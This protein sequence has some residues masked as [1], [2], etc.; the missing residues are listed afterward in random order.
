[1]ISENQIYRLKCEGI[2][3][4]GK[5]VSNVDSF[6]IFID[7]F[8]TGEIADIKITK[9][10]KNFGFGIITN[11]IQKSPH[12]IDSLCGHSSLS[13]TCPFNDIT[14]E[15]ELK[16]KSEIVKH[17][18]T[19]KTSYYKDIE[20][21]SSED[22][23]GYRNKI[24]VFFNE[25]N[26]KIKY[27]YFKEK[28]NDFIEVDYC[29]QIDDEINKLLKHIIK[30]LEESNSSI[31]NIRKKVGHIKG[32][33]IRKSSYTK[34]IIIMF[35]STHNIPN[36]DFIKDNLL[37]FNKNISGIS[38][39]INKSY[40]TFIYSG[41]IIKV[42]G[43]SYIDEKI[44]DIIFRVDNLSFLQVNTS[45]ASLLYKYAIDKANLTKDDNVLDLY[46]GVG[47]ITLNLSKYVDKVYGIE[48]VESS[49]SLAKYNA[50]SNLISNSI[51]YASD[52]KNFDLFIK[53]GEIDVLFLDPPRK[54]LSKELID[55]ILFYK[56]NKIIYISC[57]PY[58][59]SNDLNLLE[60]EYKIES[61]KCFNMFP[62]TR[63]VETV[64]CLVKR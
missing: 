33:V 30:I 53:K 25:I 14:Y 51:F 47:G 19:R 13:G 44:M 45:C 56:F 58:T 61:I 8:Y 64:C 32:V 15:Y 21:I 40:D 48:E 57:D 36:I 17:N 39:N 10:Y 37:S 34:K 42:Y 35:L 20:C 2:N 54:G 3:N 5:G 52:S 11:L 41:K 6:V 31:A 22:I 12:R 1:M 16:L 28:S 9:V 29:V 62:R 18:I 50:K 55:K 27:G 49:I 46:C 26:G 4:Y 63:H 60:K 24:T 43:D 59:L 7:D 23:K 38:I